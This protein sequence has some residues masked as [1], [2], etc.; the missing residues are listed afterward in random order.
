MNTKKINF[1]KCFITGYFLAM[2]L[3]LAVIDYL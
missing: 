1:S 2:A 3:F